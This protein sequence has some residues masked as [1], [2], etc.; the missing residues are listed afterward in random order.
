MWSAVFRWLWATGWLVSPFPSVGP[1]A[2][3][4][5]CFSG[6]AGFG[7][8]VVAAVGVGVGVVGAG[9]PWTWSDVGSGSGVSW[10]VVRSDGKAW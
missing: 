2:F 3:C 8:G 7:V 4:M 10:W 5:I 1:K 9:W 6:G